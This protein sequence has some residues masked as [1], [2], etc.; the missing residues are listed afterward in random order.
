MVSWPEIIAR[1]LNVDLQGEGIIC[2]RLR[3][4]MLMQRD[5][6]STVPATT[7]NSALGQLPLC[8]VGT[9]DMMA[10]SAPHDEQPHHLAP[11]DHCLSSLGSGAM[12]SNLG[13]F[14]EVGCP[15]PNCQRKPCLFSH[16][17]ILMKEAQEGTS[18]SVN[19][20]VSAQSSSGRET[21][22]REDA[23][24]ARP[25]TN[26]HEEVLNN[27]RTTVSGLRLVHQVAL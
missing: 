25:L 27:R 5:Y 18:T 19:R 12:F 17:P 4:N 21:S 16:N 7:R 11:S 14:K 23:V 9:W 3:A 2:R 20:A 26:A 8:Q 24:K 10:P 22:R 1:V 13:L 15:D 6:V